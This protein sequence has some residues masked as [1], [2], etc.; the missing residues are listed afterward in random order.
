MA[1]RRW[2]RSAEP[3]LLSPAQFLAMGAQPDGTVVRVQA[4]ATAGVNW[5]FRFNAGSTNA[6]KWEA[7]GDQPSLFSEV[8]VAEIISFPANDPSYR[9]TP[10]PGPTVTV[11]LAGDYDLLYGLAFIV[12]AAGYTA[13]ASLRI[14]AAVPVAADELRCYL[15]TGAGAAGYYQGDARKRRKTGLAAAT[16]L[17]MQYA[18]NNGASALSSTFDKR[19]MDVRPLRV[20]GP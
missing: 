12:A 18:Y 4:D 10:T 11:P 6:A 19:W 1:R 2:T 14:G 7:D 8:N 13:T 17:K 3:E 9:D 20:Q 16:A 5:R 15:V